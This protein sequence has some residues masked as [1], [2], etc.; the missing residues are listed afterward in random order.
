MLFRT[1]IA[2]KTLRVALAGGGR[3]ALQH[4]TAIARHRGLAELVG[5]ADPSPAARAA[6]R[7]V[8]PGVP[9]F[10]SLA[11][12]LGAVAVDVVHVCTPPHTHATLAALAVEAGCHVYVE[13]PF[14][15]SAD[16]AERVLS[17]AARRGL[18]VCAGHQCL[19]EHPATQAQALLPSLGE[20]V[21]V[22]SFFAFAPVAGHATGRAPLAPHRQLL[23]VLPHPV[24][25]LEHFLRQADPHSP[26]DVAALEVGPRGTVHAFVRCGRLT[27][28][29]V[30]T[31][32]G[33]PVQHHLRLVGSRGVVQSDFVVGT[34]QRLIGPGT[35]S[36]DKVLAP[37][38]LARQSAGGA[39]A[40]LTSRLVRGQRGYPGLA[41]ITGAF[42]RAIQAGRAAPLSPAS[43]LT[44]QRICDRIAAAL[45]TSADVA[46]GVTGRVVGVT[47]AT[48][49]LGS[50]LVRALRDAGAVVRAV[51]RRE[52]APW[53]R[54]AGVEY[55]LADLGEPLEPAA[56]RTCEVVLHCAAA[57]RGGWSAQQRNSIDATRH[58]LT[59]AAAAGVTGV[60]HVSSLAVLASPR[61]KTVP[62]ESAPLVRN[63]R[64]RGP[65]VWGKLESERL[66]LQLGTDLGLHVKVV[67]PGAI[68]DSANYDP[69]GRLGRRLGTWF[70]AVGS[71]SDR[72]AVVERR[73]A[74]GALA[75][76]ALHFTEAPE[77]LHLVAPGPTTKRDLVAQLRL[78]NPDL[79]IVW[80][81]RVLLLPLA[82]LA[83]AVQKALHPRRATTNIASAFAPQEV[84][85]SRIR[86][87]APVVP[88]HRMRDPHATG[89]SDTITVPG[90]GLRPRPPVRQGSSLALQTSEE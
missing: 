71:P 42:Y 22:E 13:K 24:Y 88:G 28:T 87:L 74:A 75:W 6:I 83:V 25:L 79:S 33:R 60:I 46:P 55:V 17:L 36:L 2:T 72:V 39:A 5:V 78:T 34:V 50:E 81:P 58:L 12:L 23:D 84:D 29:L 21:H 9:E 77:T 69:P 11:D 66:A 85:T 41:E 35:S 26:M 20:L 32:D 43:I 4:A 90:V 7:R 40:A 1:A 14:T 73:F 67:R 18:Q 38:R 59:G 44:T 82:W 51:V 68:V 80:L 89:P 54:V 86:A 65:Y 70:V 31:L 62:D 30:V 37:F 53:E 10:D 49:F 57:T 3:M 61:G 47:G 15:E 27:G 19:F 8:W 76:L 45:T 48:G 52:P 16:D 63:P 64:K 56:L